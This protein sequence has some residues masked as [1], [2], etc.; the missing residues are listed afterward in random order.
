M[1]LS[2]LCNNENINNYNSKIINNNKNSKINNIYNKANESNTLALQN[3]KN[4]T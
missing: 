4:F 2:K 3:F 1:S